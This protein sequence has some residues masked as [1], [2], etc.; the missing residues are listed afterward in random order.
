[1]S[2]HQQEEEQKQFVDI[3]DIKEI[4][5]LIKGAGKYVLAQFR[6]KN[7]LDPYW[8]GLKSQPRQIIAFSVTILGSPSKSRMIF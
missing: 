8:E 4:V 3:A 7:T 2:N 1:M 5:K 6:P